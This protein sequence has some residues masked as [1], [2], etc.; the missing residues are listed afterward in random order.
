MKRFF[1]DRFVSESAVQL[2]TK[3]FDVGVTFVTSDTKN[4]VVEALQLLNLETIHV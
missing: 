2:L 3:A 4:Y 1:Y